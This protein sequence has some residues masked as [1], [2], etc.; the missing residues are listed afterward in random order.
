M[1][2]YLFYQ[3]LILLMLLYIFNLSLALFLV[4]K[5]QNQNQKTFNV[6]Q[7]GKFVYH[8]SD[9]IL[10]KQKHITRTESHV[11]CS[12]TAILSCSH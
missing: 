3:I 2:S 8:S 7:T 5:S 11:V 10:Q 4:C 9:R 1:I 12:C 6:P